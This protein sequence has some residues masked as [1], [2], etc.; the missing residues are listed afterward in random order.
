MNKLE[1]LRYACLLILG[2]INHLQLAPFDFLGLN[3]LNK[4]A[5]ES[6]PPMLGIAIRTHN[7]PMDSRFTVLT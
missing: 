3:L 5:S 6:I 4:R 2:F 7:T 1:T